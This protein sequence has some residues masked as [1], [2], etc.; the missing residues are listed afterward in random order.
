MKIKVWIIG[1]MILRGEI[2]EYLLGEKS[3]PVPIS[4]PQIQTFRYHYASK[5]GVSNKKMF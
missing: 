5:N 2:D 4:L 3:G 1:Y